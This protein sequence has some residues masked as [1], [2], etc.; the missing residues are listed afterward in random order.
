MSI[1]ESY[2]GVLEKGTTRFQGQS[3][4][5]PVQLNSSEIK[6]MAQRMLMLPTQQCGFQGR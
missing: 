4:E 5:P 3:T 6:G 2:E 1:W